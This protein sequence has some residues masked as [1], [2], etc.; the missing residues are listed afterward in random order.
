MSGDE[1]TTLDTSVLS[2]LY[3]SVGGD[4][5]FIADLVETYLTDGAAQLAA[6]DAA[7]GDREAEGLVRPA[8]TLKSASRTSRRKL[9]PASRLGQAPHRSC[10]CSIHAIRERAS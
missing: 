4:D 1:T 6:I 3:D 8:H 10:C 9:W 5:A 7:A 2:A